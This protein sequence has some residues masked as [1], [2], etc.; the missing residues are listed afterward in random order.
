[1]PLIS[2]LGWQRQTGICKVRASLLFELNFGVTRC[3]KVRV[4]FKIIIIIIK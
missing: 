2:A 3:Y 4:H 1:M